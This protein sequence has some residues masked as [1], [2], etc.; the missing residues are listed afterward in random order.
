MKKNSAELE[1]QNPLKVFKTLGATNHAVSERVE[2]DYYA[3][4][5]SMVNDLLKV[6]YFGKDILEP[7]CGEGH[8]AKFL[9]EKGYNVTATDLINRGYGKVKD[10]L[11]YTE[12]H[13]DIITNPP[14]KILVDCMRTFL[15]IVPNGS[16]VALLLR[17]LALEGKA[18]GEIY[19]EFPLKAYYVYRHRLPCVVRNGEFDTCTASA[20]NYAWY[21]W[22]KGYKGKP[23][24]EWI[25]RSAKDPMF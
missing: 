17:I 14:Y 3:T 19:D 24:I 12:W 16:K 5:P 21:V 25:K 8:I 1:P 15:E 4:H 18:R 2:Y 20:M 13:G 22:E 9:T 11:D 23:V 6:E 10:C 7:C